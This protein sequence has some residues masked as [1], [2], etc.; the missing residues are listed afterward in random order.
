MQKNYFLVLA[1]I[2][3]KKIQKERCRRN[4]AARASKSRRSGLLY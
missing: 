2:A 1:I 3:F 4:I